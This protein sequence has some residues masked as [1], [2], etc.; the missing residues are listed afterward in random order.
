M[1]NTSQL[2]SLLMTSDLMIRVRLYCPPIKYYFDSFMTLLS[3]KNHSY[4]YKVARDSKISPSNIAGHYTS[5]DQR[6]WHLKIMPIQFSV[7]VLLKLWTWLRV[8]GEISSEL[9]HMRALQRSYQPSF[10][11]SDHSD[12][13]P[14]ACSPNLLMVGLQSLHLLDNLHHRTNAISS[15]P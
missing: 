6:K 2:L 3:E 15:F 9:K 4:S 11:F 5:H 13:V 1:D 12:V 10:Q 7:T 14:I 8:T